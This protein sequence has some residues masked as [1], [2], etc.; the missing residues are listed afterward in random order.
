MGKKNGHRE[1]EP[2]THQLQPDLPHLTHFSESTARW[3]SSLQCEPKS[4]G[5]SHGPQLTNRITMHVHVPPNTPHV[6]YVRI[7]MHASYYICTTDLTKPHPLMPKASVLP[8]TLQLCS[9]DPESTH[10]KHMNNLGGIYYFLRT[11]TIRPSVRYITL[12]APRIFFPPSQDISPILGQFQTFYLWLVTV[13]ARAKYA[14][15]VRTKPAG[16]TSAYVWIKGG[17]RGRE[18]VEVRQAAKLRGI[19]FHL[20]K[21]YKPKLI[22]YNGSIHGDFIHV[23]F[24]IADPPEEIENVR[25]KYRRNWCFRGCPYR[26]Y[27]VLRTC[28]CPRTYACL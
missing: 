23:S 28:V 2:S 26:Y 8:Q 19:I 13:L 14:Y 6:L 9:V 10:T 22:V 5:I 25:K 3:V 24:I 17:S 1:G 15:Y 4:A 18:N 12:L 11:R 16:S 27:V 21:R 7:R 20:A